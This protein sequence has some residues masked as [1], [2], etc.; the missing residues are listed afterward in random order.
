MKKEVKTD[1]KNYKKIYILI[2]L[3]VAI[4]AISMILRPESNIEANN[5]TAEIQKNV[6]SEVEPQ[7]EIPTA[8]IDVTT[9]LVDAEKPQFEIYADGSEMPIKQADWMPRYG[10][11]GYVVQEKGYSKDFVIKSLKDAEIRILLKG[12]DKRDENN[13]IIENWVDYVSFSVDGKDILPEKTAAWHNK[14]FVHVLNAKSGE[15]HKIKVKWE[16]HNE[17]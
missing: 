12:P 2:T 11:Q 6:V 4:L 17:N 7:E 9:K 1:E 13:K 8:R 15:E 3:V 16:S 14:P 5:K 10:I